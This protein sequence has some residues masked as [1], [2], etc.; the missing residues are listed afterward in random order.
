MVPG[1]GGGAH[2][3]EEELRSLEI[4]YFSSMIPKSYVNF[5]GRVGGDEKKLQLKLFIKLKWWQ[6][7]FCSVKTRNEV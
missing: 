7:L 6:F 2:R 3:V 1:E 5:H 4:L